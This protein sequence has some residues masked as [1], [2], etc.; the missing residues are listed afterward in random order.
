MPKPTRQ[1]ISSFNAFQRRQQIAERRYT[2]QFFA[3]LRK[4][5]YAAARAYEKG[6]YQFQEVVDNQHFTRIMKRLYIQFTL[7]EAK[8]QYQE[9]F[10]EFEET[11]ALGKK[12]MID[13]LVE[14]LNPNDRGLIRMWRELLDEFIEVR[15]AERLNIINNTT[16]ERIIKIIEQGQ[17]EGLGAEEVARNIRRLGSS[18]ITQVRSRAIARTET[19]TAGNQGKF[20]SAKSS[21]LVMDKKWLPAKDARTRQG[22]YEML[23]KDW[24]GLDEDFL[25]RNEEGVLEPALY[26]CDNRLSA[27]N[28]VNCRC[29]LIFKPKRDENGRLLIKR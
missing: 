1:H 3:F 16:R 25:V 11:P 13:D 24:I 27:S 17:F 21:N 2:K 12:D 19:I 15:I 5:H 28:I 10:A 22:H 9:T 7:Q 6:N 20:L 26:P 4:T 8:L 23:L 18:E 14:I 29:S